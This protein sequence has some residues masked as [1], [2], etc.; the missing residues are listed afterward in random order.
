MSWMPVALAAY[1]LLAVAN[2]LDKFLVD[3][4][5][6]NSRA[7]A[8]I[9]CTLGALVFLAAPWF[10][11]WP[12]WPLFLFNILN[13]A[14]FAVAIW[15]LY[16]ALR[17]GEAARVLVFIGGA[18]PV[19]SLLFSL[20]FFKERFSGNQWLGMA[21][22]L[23]GIFIIAFLPV[24]RGFMSRLWRKLGVAPRV[25]QGGLGV[26]AFS[27]LAYSLYFIGTKQ[28]YFS[29]PFESAFIWT[30]LGAVIFVLFFLLRRD[31]RQAIYKTFRPSGPNKNKFLVI[32]NQGIGSVGFI[33]QNY[34]IFLGSVVLVNAMQGTQ[35][36]FLLIISAALALLAPRFLKENFSW[37][38]ILQKAAAVIVIFFG[39]YFMSV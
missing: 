28:A 35:Y 32:F 8:F 34:A 22:L 23:S 30:R 29:Q 16:E 14:I 2:L 20:L 27:A 9:A 11:E 31:N 1:L 24:A 7:Y 18:T 25:G 21:L 33:L 12:G 36:A 19:F 13:G 17:R 15:L 26:A 3:N 38:I 37:R 6:K 39:L 5:L 4:V 10:L